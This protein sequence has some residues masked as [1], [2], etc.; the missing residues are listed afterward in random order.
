MLQ[1]QVQLNPEMIGGAHSIREQQ[2]QQLKSNTIDVYDYLDQ[3]L[4]C[5]QQ[6]VN[7]EFESENQY[8]LEKAIRPSQI[9]IIKKTSQ[10]VPKVIVKQR[11]E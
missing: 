5:T 7:R 6:L 1:P 9:Q 10:V 2:N 11:N 3:E 4:E 8:I